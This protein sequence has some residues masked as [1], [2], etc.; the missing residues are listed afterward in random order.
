VRFR[1]HKATTQITFYTARPYHP[2][3]ARQT[4]GERR[5]RTQPMKRRQKR[6]VLLLSILLG[7]GLGSWL[8]WRTGAESQMHTV[9]SIQPQQAHC[10]GAQATLPARRGK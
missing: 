6:F 2:Q 5:R 3:R 1:P 8:G 7:I 9:P 10:L 4:R